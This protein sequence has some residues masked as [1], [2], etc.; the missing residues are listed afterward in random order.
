MNALKIARDSHHADAGKLLLEASPTTMED[1]ASRLAR[2]FLDQAQCVQEMLD[3]I[4]RAGSIQITDQ[5]DYATRRTSISNDPNEP[6]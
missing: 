3:L 2:Q 1:V 4:E 5:E 6:A